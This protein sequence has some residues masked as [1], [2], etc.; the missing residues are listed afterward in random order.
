[1]F[2]LNK[3]S[4]FTFI[5]ASIIS[6]PLCAI[7]ITE[8]SNDEQAIKSV[9]ATQNSE[10]ATPVA[11]IETV[12]KVEKAKTENAYET[13]PKVD[14]EN[15]TFVEPPKSVK[16]TGYVSDNQEYWTT[17]GP[18]KQYRVSIRVNAG[19][20]VY[21]LNEQNGYYNIFTE[22]GKSAWISKKHIQQEPSNLYKVKNLT[23]ENQ[24]YKYRL[25]NF[26]SET[27]RELKKTKTEL[28]ALKIEHN[29]LLEDHKKL[30]EKAE[31]LTTEN[32]RLDEASGRK[33]QEEMIKFLTRGGLI[34]A[35]GILVGVIL[36]YLPRP[37]RRNKDYY[38]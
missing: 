6:S 28:D 18:G 12:K 27:A 1:M 29:K 30:T 14:T 4:I 16:F 38:Y 13:K 24:K 23:T 10:T 31:F 26:D 33:E 8:V 11:K 36:V 9:S 25:E 20:K 35:G 22:D 5:F 15:K 32:A 37:R 17:R 19:D 7:E 3:K 34:A 2:S 21:V